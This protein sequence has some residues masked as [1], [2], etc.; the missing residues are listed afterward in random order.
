MMEILET[1]PGVIAVKFSGRMRAEEIDEV[2]T[3][4]EC[5]LEANERTHVYVEIH[6]N[7]SFDVGAMAAYLPR[8]AAMLTKLDRFGRIAVVTEERWIRWATKIESAILP[9]ISYETFELA[10]HVEALAWVEGRQTLP[11][12]PSIMIME[13]DKPDVIGFEID[14]KISAIEAKAVVAYFSAALEADR[15]LRLLGKMKHIGGAELGAFFDRAFLKMK[16]DI[17]GRLDRYAIVG[18]PSWLSAWVTALD[19]LTK[20]DIRHF[21]ASDEPLAWQWLDAN[22][23]RHHPLVS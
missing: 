4:V 8:G 21:K 13:T 5:S 22:P 11:H 15:P 10:E 6:D 12:A 3:L 1:E 20:A 2:A 16:Y 9:G 19:K 7:F 17:L 14:G 18:G 23:K